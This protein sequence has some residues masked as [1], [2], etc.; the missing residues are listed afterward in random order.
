MSELSAMQEVWEEKIKRDRLSLGHSI[1]V[2]INAIGS[3]LFGKEFKGIQATDVFKFPEREVIANEE[4][5]G[6]S[7]GEIELMAW[8]QAKEVQRKDLIIREA[9]ERDRL[10]HG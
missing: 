4:R 6:P 8:L 7:V 9:M 2:L 10:A 5:E 1:A 3:F